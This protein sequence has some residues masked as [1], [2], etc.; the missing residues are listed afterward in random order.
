LKDISS[1]L[2]P[3]T[4]STENKSNEPEKQPSKTTSLYNLFYEGLENGSN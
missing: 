1:K 4:I 2:E 3:I